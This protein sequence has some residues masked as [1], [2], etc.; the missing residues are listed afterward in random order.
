MTDMQSKLLEQEARIEALSAAL[1][2]YFASL[3]GEERAR[4][5]D[6]ILPLK[7]SYE[8]ID[9]RCRQAFDHVIDDL[10]DHLRSD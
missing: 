2:L 5:R 8:G 3:A 10:L 4:A 6:W 9:P 1:R 7:G